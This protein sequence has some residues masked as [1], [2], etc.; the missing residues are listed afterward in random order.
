MKS[1]EPLSFSFEDAERTQLMDWVQLS[2]DMKIDFFEEMLEIAY[3]SGAL[4]PQKL[5]LREGTTQ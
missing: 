4:T 1:T 2:A 5:A 3:L